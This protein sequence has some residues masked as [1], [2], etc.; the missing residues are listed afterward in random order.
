MGDADGPAAEHDR[1]GRIGGC[2]AVLDLTALHELAARAAGADLSPADADEVMAAA[3]G[4]ERCI[5][6]LRAAA[7]RAHV[8]LEAE[9]ATEIRSGLRTSGWLAWEARQSIPAC[10]RRVQAAVRLHRDL[11]ELAAA[12]EQGRVGW[13]HV[14]VLCSVANARNLWRVREALGAFIDA[15]EATG[16][17][18]LRFDAWARRVRVAAH[19]W[20]EDGGHDPNEDL[21]ANRLR[22]DALPDGT[23]EL[24]G[25]IVGDGAVVVTSTLEGI[26]D[27]LF[28]QFARDHDLEPS[29]E[30]P[31]RSTLMGL[32]L[33][34]ACRRATAVDLAS[35]QP[36]R[37]EA[38]V[39]VECTPGGEL[40]ATDE[41]GRPVSVAAL[42][43]LLPGANLRA[44][45]V[46]EDGN[47]LRMGRATRF[48]TPHQKAAL[49]CRDRG[50]IFPGCDR[51]PAWCDGHHV[52]P[53]DEGG[54]TDIDHLA[55]LCR[56]HHRLTHQPGWEMRP[57]PLRSQHWSWTTP[58]GRTLHS[59]RS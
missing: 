34:E 37:T 55:S 7:A 45:V 32:A 39:V 4:L 15:A 8:R 5:D 58:T 28:A 1:T 11:P 50:C 54:R 53:W 33:V 56:T 25:R 51:P 10:R 3:A 43:A 52:P 16:R 12:L 17:D 22:V 44:L 20:D 23:R 57:D 36:A 49:A 47:P 26:A 27:E 42:T 41:A 14:E 13:S 31:T 38:I 19:L 2:G 21:H 29:I 40:A 59:Q 6:L 35:S 46:D 9:G 48:A 24:T 30:V 18:R